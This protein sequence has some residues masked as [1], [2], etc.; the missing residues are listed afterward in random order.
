M[1]RRP[2]RSTLDRS[3]AAS[4]VYKRQQ[5]YTP[6]V[7]VNMECPLLLKAVPSTKR[8]MDMMQIFLQLKYLSQHLFA[9]LVELPLQDIFEQNAKP[10]LFLKYPLHEVIGFVFLRLV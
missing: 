5:G 1:I 4:D 7:R 6:N 2:P 9:D 8:H 10:I 3:S